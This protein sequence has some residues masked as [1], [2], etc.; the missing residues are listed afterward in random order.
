MEY[1]SHGAM[2]MTTATGIPA[3][4]NGIGRLFWEP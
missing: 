2:T 1:Q 3:K 4:M